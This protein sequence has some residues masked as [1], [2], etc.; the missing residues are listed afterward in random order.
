MG[1]FWKIGFYKVARLV[2]NWAE[3]KNLQIYKKDK[4]QYKANKILKFYNQ[5][6][7]VHKITT[8]KHTGFCLYF[9][10]TLLKPTTNDL[11]PLQIVQPYNKH[12]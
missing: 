6:F 5:G 12:G 9:Y 4:T 7:K 2:L 11:T 3:R 8:R 1:F 10:I